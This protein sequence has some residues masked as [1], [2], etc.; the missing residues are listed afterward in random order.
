MA[1]RYVDAKRWSWGWMALCVGGMVM[2][3]PAADADAPLRIEALQRCGNLLTLDTQEFCLDVSG[4][5]GAAYRVKLDGEP[6]PADHIEQQ[7][8]SFTPAHRRDAGRERP[9]MDRT[10]GERQQPGMVDVTRQPCDRGHAR[11]RRR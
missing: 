10:A 2:M 6:L 9:A 7:G 3:T 5:N 4:L 11:G 1:G 8:G